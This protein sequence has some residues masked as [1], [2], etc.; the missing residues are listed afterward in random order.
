MKS[1]AMVD[2]NQPLNEED[3]VFLDYLRFCMT[4]LYE[5]GAAKG[6]AQTLKSASDPATGLADTAYNILNIAGDKVD[7][8]LDEEL[9]PLLAITLLQEVAEIGES[10][11][12]QYQGEE[13]A[14]ALKMM[15]LRFLQ[16]SG[17]DA[18]QLESAMSQVDKSVFNQAGV[19]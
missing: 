11:G 17:Y 1:E 6:V 13:L 8:E 10:A 4:A 16:E 18:S 5:K 15:I 12:V 9:L 2:D 7:G 3:P 14:D 19:M